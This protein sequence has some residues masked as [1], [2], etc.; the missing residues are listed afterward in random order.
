MIAFVAIAASAQGQMAPPLPPVPSAADRPREAVS[1]PPGITP[2]ETVPLGSITKSPVDSAKLDLVEFRDQPLGEA[3][4]LFAAQ[5]GLNIVAS[6][7]ARKV[8]VALYLRDV[9]AEAALDALCKS[10]DLW[11]KQ[12]PSSGVIRI[13]TAKEYQRDLTSFR[14]E[15]TEVFTLLYPNPY[16]GP[17]KLDHDFR[18][19]RW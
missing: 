9:T 13:S 18:S 5:T 11:H 19:K 7:E 12:D 14:E 4:R 8:V 15:Q 3:M 16:S 1:P 2:L 17:Q 10:N 6:P